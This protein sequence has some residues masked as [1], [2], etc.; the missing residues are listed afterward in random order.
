MGDTAEDEIEKNK[1]FHIDK[2]GF[3]CIPCGC[4]RQLYQKETKTVK[5]NDKVTTNTVVD[6]RNLKF[7][8]RNVSPDEIFRTDE[9]EQ[10]GSVAICD[11]GWGQSQVTPEELEDKIDK[12]ETEVERIDK[13]VTILLVYNDRP[14]WHKKS[15]PMKTEEGSEPMPPRLAGSTGS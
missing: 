12:L 10:T 11:T 2:K 9:A 13:N 7:G 8:G 4:K 6:K 15:P 5:E 1:G 3:H 14:S